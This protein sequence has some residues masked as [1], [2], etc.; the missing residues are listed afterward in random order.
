MR[1]GGPNELYASFYS[2][3]E[4]KPD[5][6]ELNNAGEQLKQDTEVTNNNDETTTKETKLPQTGNNPFAYIIILILV[7]ITIFSVLRVRQIND[8]K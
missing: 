8:M 4:N 3:D 5:N 2:K 1:Y 6:N 7:V